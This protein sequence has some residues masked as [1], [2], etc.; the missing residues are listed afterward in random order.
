MELENLNYVILAG[1]WEELTQYVNDF[2]ADGWKP[3][4]GICLDMKDQFYQAMMRE[5][6]KNDK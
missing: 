3:I 5:S 4:G 6:T 1:S 2:I